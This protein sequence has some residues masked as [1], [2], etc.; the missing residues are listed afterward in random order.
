MKVILTIEIE[1]TEPV[2]EDRAE[3][4]LDH[5]VEV[6]ASNGLLTEPGGTLETWDYTVEWPEE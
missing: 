5:A 1:L 2:D 3:R 4:A 6:L